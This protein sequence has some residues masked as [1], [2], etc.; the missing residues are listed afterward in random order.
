MCLS[1]CICRKKKLDEGF[2]VELLIRRT[3]PPA[4]GLV[5]KKWKIFSFY[6]F[7]ALALIL[8]MYMPGYYS[9][10]FLLGVRNNRISKSTN[11]C[12]V[13]SACPDIL[14]EIVAFVS[15]TLELMLF[16]QYMSYK[17]Y[18][19]FKRERG[20]TFK[21]INAS[22]NAIIPFM[23]LCFIGEFVISMEYFLKFPKTCTVSFFKRLGLTV[24]AWWYFYA[25]DS[26]LCFIVQGKIPHFPVMEEGTVKKCFI[27]LTSQLVLYSVALDKTYIQ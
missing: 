5:R 24:L 26:C 9:S 2:C 27:F 23:W 14:Q 25:Y 3:R 12:C 8:L 7:L 21:R 10:I 13:F 18:K 22:N 11:F 20:N 6:L 15:I 16:P 19:C 4:S 17:T 1:L